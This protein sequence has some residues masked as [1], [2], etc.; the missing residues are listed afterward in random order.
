MNQNNAGYFLESL[1][2]LFTKKEYQNKISF[3][4]DRLSSFNYE[5]D[6]IF[7]KKIK[8]SAVLVI[9]NLISKG[10][11]TRP[12]LYVEQTISDYYLKAKKNIDSGGNI[13]FEILKEDIEENIIRALHIINE[14]PL[15]TKN[16][17]KKKKEQ[18]KQKILF[19]VIKQSIGE[20]IIAEFQPNKTFEDIYLGFV[21]DNKYETELFTLETSPFFKSK[22]DFVLEMPYVHNQKKGL[23][24]DLDD[25]D[26]L[27][28]TNYLLIESK[29]EFAQRL[30]YEY[31]YLKNGHYDE[32]VQFILNFTYNEYFDTLKKNYTTP[33]YTR[34]SG[35]DALQV[36][37]APFGIA[38][39]QKVILEFIVAQ[40]LNL[41]STKWKIAVI[42]RDVVAANI[43]LEDLKQ[44]FANLHI[45]IGKRNIL[46]EIELTVYRNPKF[47]NIKTDK[48]FN[49][50]LKKISEFD[51]NEKYDLLID[52]SIFQN[53]SFDE[54][55]PF[56][57]SAFTVKIRSSNSNNPVTPLMFGNLIAYKPFL[58]FEKKS[59]NEKL[60]E[61]MTYFLRNIFRKNEFICNQ[62]T[63]IN[64]T[65]QLKSFLNISQPATGKTFAYVYAALMQPASS[66]VCVPNDKLIKD[67]FL[68]LKSNRVDRT[69][70]ISN[71]ENRIL[72]RLEAYNKLSKGHSLLTFISPETIATECFNDAILKFE[73]NKVTSGYLIIDEAQVLSQNNVD[74]STD[75]IHIS[76]L[77][78]NN[79]N[80]AKMPIIAMTSDYSI[81]TKNNICETL[82]I[83]DVL[84]YNLTN[85]EIDYSVIDVSDGES[86]VKNYRTALK[87][88][89]KRKEFMLIDFL[90]KIDNLDSKIL[91]VCPDLHAV[92]QVEQVLNKEFKQLEILNFNKLNQYS[93][94]EQGT[95]NILISDQSIG[96]GTDL[97]ITDRVILFNFTPS[98]QKLHQLAGRVGR[99]SNKA[100]VTILYDN[101]KTDLYNYNETST[102]EGNI[103][104]ME[105]VV[106][107]S[108]D[109]IRAL[110]NINKTFKGRR[111]E[112]SILNEILS[113]I[114]NNNKSP[115]SIIE[116]EVE[117][118]FDIN[119]I[120]KKYPKEEPRRII[121]TQNDKTY[122]YITLNNSVI[123]VLSTDFEL[124][125]SN[126]IM[127]FV[128]NKLQNIYG[129]EIKIDNEI[130]Q[131][132]KTIEGIEVE[133]SKLKKGSSTEIIFNLEN[134]VFDK[135][136]KLLV[137]NGNPDLREKTLLEIWDNNNH[138]NNFIEELGK[139]A[140]INTVT[141]DVDVKEELIKW[142]YKFRNSNSTLLALY[143]LK[144]LNIIDKYL[145]DKSNNSVTV[146]L[147]SNVDTLYKKSLLNYI[148]NHT[149]HTYV[150]EVN[151]LLKNYIGKTTIQKYVNFL[152]N[153]IYENNLNSN[154]VALDSPEN[155]VE[156]LND[157]KLKGKKLD[158][159]M[160]EFYDNYFKNKYFNKIVEPDLFADIENNKKGSTFI[161]Q[162]YIREIGIS[163]LNREYLLK[164]TEEALKLNEDNYTLKLL[165]SYCLLAESPTNID[166][167]IDV[168]IEA[169]NQAKK[170]EN[171][172]YEQITSIKSEFLDELIIINKKL[173]SELEPLL[174]IS[175]S[176]AWIQEFNEKFSEGLNKYLKN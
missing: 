158:K 117:Q 57:K 145:I 89:F 50:N 139:I 165:K 60:I 75:S 105:E 16:K 118:Q 163:K 72:G 106:K 26:N 63:V 31:I 79:A 66:L 2:K 172:N 86:F 100:Q 45:L 109:K 58:K 150:E 161:T 21:A 137:D 22:I 64:K 71:K 136:Y 133:L 29:K 48:L 69:F 157:E 154:V 108:P 67:E 99:K 82:D 143:R 153:F 87:K 113:K 171:L 95:A 65:L 128:K 56:S 9:N 30:N 114:E 111:K 1:I 124:K 169:F 93:E 18:F 41:N 107:I 3:L 38:R 77:K 51:N 33:L 55:T 116:R 5:T 130:T 47:K 23:L 53:L 123:N 142:F 168:I 101:S 146:Y 166:E 125:L 103:E 43:A 15:F 25:D 96:L 88:S 132:P 141:V 122:G 119:I 160:S 167:S 4:I 39:I 13:S 112:I 120:L 70:Y 17:S 138:D 176:L 12:S 83:N 73:L 32:A 159:L 140:D 84:E 135:I 27:Q 144:M 156:V 61:S 80:N 121:V 134:G 49:F 94:F 36:A 170:I 90:N 14:K 173:K 97:K 149:S 126:E 147:K 92:N 78:Y 7:N 6:A 52:N 74:F 59:N 155:L 152:I 8:N 10:I 151:I 127:L 102:I 175:D 98:I 37:L 115:F 162:K 174:K 110:N 40:K 28:N 35:I 164:S 11:S 104:T 85:R 42:E 148:Q 129:L 91:I 24:I 76:T 81:E 20:Y 54:K 68:N 34:T 44:Q 131:F 46:P 62:A 19:E